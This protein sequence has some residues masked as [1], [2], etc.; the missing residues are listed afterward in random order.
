MEERN[1]NPISEEIIS[2][3][4]NYIFP[5]KINDNLGTC[6]F[7]NTIS[8]IYLCINYNILPEEYIKSKGDIKINEK[9]TI[10]LDEKR[11]IIPF[12]NQ[13]KFIKIEDSDKIPPNY[14]LDLENDLNPEQY[15]GRD[16]YLFAYYN[17]S[18][19]FL[20]I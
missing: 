17:T 2:E 20:R 15:I 11:R 3:S 5:I 8:A 9:L 18:R 14:I 7:I 13:C 6:F 19:R 1:L 4:K 10:K 16:A 12:N